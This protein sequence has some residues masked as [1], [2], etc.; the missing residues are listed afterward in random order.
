ME[1]GDRSSGLWKQS[2]FSKL[3]RASRGD[4]NEG[5]QKNCYHLIFKN[6]TK[7]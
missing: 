6:T 7:R 3:A 4:I 5:K 1:G 2:H